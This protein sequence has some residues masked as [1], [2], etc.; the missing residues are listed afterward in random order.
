MA[1][2][3]GF[4]PASVGVRIQGLTTWRHPNIN[5]CIVKLFIAVCQFKITLFFSNKLT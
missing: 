1:G 3:A 4:E 2:V 5:E